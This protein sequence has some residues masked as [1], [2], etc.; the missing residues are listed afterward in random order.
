MVSFDR[1]YQLQGQEDSR[2]ESIHN[3][4]KITVETDSFSG[5][6]TGENIESSLTSKLKSVIIY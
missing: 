1:Y 4:S 3:E 2:D 5:S 6:E